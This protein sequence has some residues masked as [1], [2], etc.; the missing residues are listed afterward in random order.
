MI[1]FQKRKEALSVEIDSRERSLIHR[2]FIASN[3]YLQ[4]VYNTW[5]SELFEMLDFKKEM[6][7]LDQVSS[8]TFGIVNEYETNSGE[9]I[10]HFD[11][12]RMDDPNTPLVTFCGT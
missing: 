3:P 9:K 4:S 8:P 1:T 2:H 5:Y 6:K 10:F 11:F 7:V 12:Y